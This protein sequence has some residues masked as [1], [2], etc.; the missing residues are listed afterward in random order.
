MARYSDP[1]ALY[2][3]QKAYFDKFP[4]TVREMFRTIVAEGRNDAVQLTSGTVSSSTLRKMGHPFG[5]S[6]SGKLR[7][8]IPTLPINVQSGKLRKSVNMKL[9]WRNVRGESYGLYFSV[10]YAKYILS[11]GGTK[12]MVARGFQGEMEKRWKAR[13]KAMI[14]H[15]RGGG[16]IK[17]AA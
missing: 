9:L 5:R 8:G 16:D 1:V 12:F 4:K 7:G 13:K 6:S 15:L 14:Q 11:K 2:R 17:V 3:S 10:G